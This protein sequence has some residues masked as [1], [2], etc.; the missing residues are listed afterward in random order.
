MNEI[1]E[2]FKRNKQFYIGLGVGIL[3]GTVATG[4]YF[5]FR[6]NAIANKMMIDS[7]KLLELNYKSTKNFYTT[8]IEIDAPGNSG[9]VVKDL[10]TGAIYPS[11]KAAAKALDIN[12]ASIAKQMSGKIPDVKGHTFEKLID[13]GAPHV[14]AA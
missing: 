3:V 12:R 5:V 1:E 7:Q 9:N 6:N 13:G 4:A 2:H 11:Q 14:L 8:L 10:S